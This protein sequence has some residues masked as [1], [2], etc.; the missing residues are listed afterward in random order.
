MVEQEMTTTMDQV[1]IMIQE[2]M[3]VMEIA[4]RE[5]IVELL[6]PDQEMAELMM[7]EEAVREMVVEQMA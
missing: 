3:L 5:M 4:V 2:M 7:M 6:E 1:E